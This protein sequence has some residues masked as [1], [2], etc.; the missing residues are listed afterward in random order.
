MPAAAAGIAMHILLI[1][2]DAI[3]ARTYEAVLT[4]AGYQVAHAATAQQAIAA[5]DS[6]K[7][8]VV[9]LAL[10]MARHNS[11]EF[12]YEFKSYSEW[13]NV[14]VLLLVPRLNHDIA[15]NPS[16][17]NNLGVCEVLIRSQ[18]TLRRLCD[19]VARAG[20]TVA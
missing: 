2:P 1:E 12:L 13:Q 20:Q 17:R 10:E 7:P 11:I 3:L 9:V 8:D 19:A 6:Q 16:I 18:L 15:D 5:A 14:P 4:D